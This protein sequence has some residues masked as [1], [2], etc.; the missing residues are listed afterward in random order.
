MSIKF[1]YD[2]TRFRLTNEAKLIHFIRKVITKKLRKTGDLSFIFTSD[3]V[4]LKINQEFLGHDYFTDVISFDYG[5]DD[6]I[7]GEV[8]ISIERVKKNSRKFKTELNTEITRVML[9]G[10]LHLCGMSDMN[11]DEKK[12]MRMEEDKFLKMYEEL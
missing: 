5:V 4:L 8:Y 9:H 12:I 3:Q 10:V 6:V 7:N 1:F 11:S 2:S